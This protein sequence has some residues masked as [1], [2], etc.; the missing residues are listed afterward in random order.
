MRQMYDAIIIGAGIIGACTGYEMAKRGYKILNIDKLGDAGMGST[1]GSCAIIRFHLNPIRTKRFIKAEFAKKCEYLKNFPWSSFAGYCFLRKRKID[2]DW[3]QFRDY[4]FC[5]LEGQIEN[6]FDDV[7]HQCI[8]G[9]QDFV[10]WVRQKLPGKG[11]R[12]VPSLKK[13]HHDIPIERI[14]TDFPF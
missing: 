6:P 1:S 7:V 3:R 4:V 13:L 11:Q 9:T 10:D 5:V 8:L 14:I 12:E 2:I